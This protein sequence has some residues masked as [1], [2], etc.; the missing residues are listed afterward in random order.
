MTEC[1]SEATERL[2]D[3]DCILSRAGA[4][5]VAEPVPVAQE[6]VYRNWRVAIASEPAPMPA[7]PDWPVLRIT[8]SVRMAGGTVLAEVSTL[9][10]A[11]LAPPAPPAQA[12]AFWKC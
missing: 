4:F 10:A 6:T 8:V 1:M 9:R 12:S 7:T 11:E 5:G 3:A 2:L